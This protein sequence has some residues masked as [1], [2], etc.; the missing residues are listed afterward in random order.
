MI[1][2]MNNRVGVQWIILQSLPVIIFFIILIDFTDGLESG[3]KFLQGQPVKEFE[4]IHKDDFCENSKN[5][6]GGR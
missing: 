4:T 5:K 2:K 3:R 1:L 6:K